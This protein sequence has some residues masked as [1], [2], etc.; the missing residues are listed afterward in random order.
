MTDDLA[1]LSA[2]YQPKPRGKGKPLAKG[3]D[4]RRWMHGAPK[5]PKDKKKAEEL[6]LHVIWDVLSEEIE[7]PVTK[8]KVD[9]LRAMIRSM[10]TSRQSSDKQALL[11]RI[12]GKVVQDVDLTTGGEKITP[13]KVDNERFDRAITSL[14]DALRETISGKGTE[15]D[16]EMDTAE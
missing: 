2:E 15:P 3:Y 14:A 11:D 12:A 16:G 1:E 8:D 5:K 9:R 6:L 13:E 4:P 7:H 10:T